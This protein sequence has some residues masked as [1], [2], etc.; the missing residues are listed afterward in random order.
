MAFID[1]LKDIKLPVPPDGES[2]RR[3]YTLQTIESCNSLQT[4]QSINSPDNL[5][6]PSPNELR[7]SLS[8]SS[9]S[10]SES[11]DVSSSDTD[12]THSRTSLL[13]HQRPVEN[14]VDSEANNGTSKRTIH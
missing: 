12:S 7:Q 6:D 1:A 5:L 10:D 11:D 4:I 14:S 13:I 3:P 9:L 2:A 8:L